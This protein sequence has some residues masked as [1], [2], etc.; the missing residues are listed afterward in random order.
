[1]FRVVYVELWI[2]GSN[3]GFCRRF[4]KFWNLAFRINFCLLSSSLIFGQSLRREKRFHREG[5][6]CFRVL[7]LVSIDWVYPSSL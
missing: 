2:W 4:L 1:M 7:F 5:M 3:W 6:S